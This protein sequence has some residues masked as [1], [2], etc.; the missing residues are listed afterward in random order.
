MYQST[1]SKIF[2]EMVK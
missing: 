1:K 2:I